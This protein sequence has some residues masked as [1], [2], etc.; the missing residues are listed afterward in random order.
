MKMMQIPY[1]DIWSMLL[2]G[3]VPHR[4]NSRQLFWN[5]LFQKKKQTGGSRGH[6]F[7]ENPGS[8]SGFFSV[9]LEIPGKL[10]LHPW[11]FDKVMLHPSE[12]SRPKTN[13]PG[14]ST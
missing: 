2:S 9:P 5:G 14:S 12:V 10:K 6:T 8:F 13:I 11:K 7:L 1:L 3:Q 4:S